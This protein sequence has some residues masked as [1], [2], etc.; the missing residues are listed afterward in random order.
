M[1]KFKLSY[2][3]SFIEEFEQEAGGDAAVLVAAQE[4]GLIPQ[5]YPVAGFADLIGQ[6]GN[7][8]KRQSARVSWRKD[9]FGASLSGNRIGSF[10]QSSLTLEDGT[11]Y[12]IPS[13][14]TF[15]ATFDY[16]F[17]VNEVETRLR[18]GIRNLTNERAPLADRFFGYFA[19]AHRDYGRSYYLDFKTKF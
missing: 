2:N 6:D 7:Q 15:N 14:T 9:A 5:S 19:D 8:E 4:N 16:R 10:Y 3:G 1:G 11:R 17:D 12:I 18:F 13:M